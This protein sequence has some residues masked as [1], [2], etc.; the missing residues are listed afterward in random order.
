M[1]C[2]SRGIEL[3]KR[4]RGTEKEEKVGKEVEG[5]REEEGGRGG[6]G[7]RLVLL[8]GLRS[9]SHRCLA[10]PAL[11]GVCEVRWAGGCLVVSAKCIFFKFIFY[12][13]TSLQALFM[14]SCM[15]I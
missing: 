1:R 12:K 8:T 5:E 3:T 2:K 6:R 7:R 9:L 15:N 4:L 13:S 14:Y 10:Q 11:A